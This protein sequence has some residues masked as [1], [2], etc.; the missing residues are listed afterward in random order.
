MNAASVQMNG[1]LKL[2]PAFYVYVLVIIIFWMILLRRALREYF[3]NPA[4][5]EEGYEEKEKEVEQ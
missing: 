2:S 5:Y 4:A 3:E 1:L